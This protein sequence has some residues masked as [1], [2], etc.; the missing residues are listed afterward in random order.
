QKEFEHLSDSQ[1]SESVSFVTARSSSDPP[2]TY[3]EATQT[4]QQEEV[5][6]ED[7]IE[8][9]HQTV[10]DYETRLNE[11]QRNVDNDKNRINSLE[12]TNQTLIKNIK[13]IKDP[14]KNI[15]LVKE[16]VEVD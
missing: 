14:I 15:Q 7:R 13:D 2:P 10:L 4:V 9:L 6:Q 1:Q 11:Y 16:Q 8:L 12:S 5:Q 3:K